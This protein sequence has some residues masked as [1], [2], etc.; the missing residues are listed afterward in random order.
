M[1][2]INKCIAHCESSHNQA[3]TRDFESPTTPIRM[4]ELVDDHAR[5][6]ELELPMKTLYVCLAHRWATKEPWEDDG[7]DSYP[8]T[9]SMCCRTL[10]SNVAQHK[11]HI[12]IEGLLPAYQDAINVTR[13]LGLRYLWIDSLCIIQDEIDDKRTQISQMGTIYKNSYLTIAADGLKDHTQSFFSTR[14]WR[15]RAHEQLVRDL[16]LIHI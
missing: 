12:V 14:N 16:S 15:W 11:K 3:C 9:R 6:V 1:Q 13:R 10:K 4:L 5:L 2:F 8:H 7:D